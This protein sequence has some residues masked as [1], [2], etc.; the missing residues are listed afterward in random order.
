MLRPTAPRLAPGLALL[1]A[2]GVGLP[3]RAA[4]GQGESIRT[5]QAAQPAELEI[6]PTP[7]DFPLWDFRVGADGYATTAADFDGGPGDISRSVAGVTAGTTITLSQRFQWRLDTRGE[8]RHYEF[9]DATM[10]DPVNGDPFDSMYRAYVE[11]L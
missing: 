6:A 8:Y 10:F 7:P 4:L 2:A 9:S 5:E 1:A 11:G 3:P